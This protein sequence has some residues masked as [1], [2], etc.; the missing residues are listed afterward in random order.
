MRIPARQGEL[1][2]RRGRGG[3]TA[4]WKSLYVLERRE[5]YSNL[6]FASGKEYGGRQPHQS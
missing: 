5:R 2:W 1:W 3:S 4:L 6:R